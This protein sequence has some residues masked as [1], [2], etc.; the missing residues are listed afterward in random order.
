MRWRPV[1]VSWPMTTGMKPS[2]NWIWVVFSPFSR[3]LRLS[4]MAVSITGCCHFTVSLNSHAV[5]RLS[6]SIFP[7]GEGFP[8]KLWALSDGHPII[9]HLHRFLAFGEHV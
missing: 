3:R 1:D 2:R 6:L 4:G 7:I 5:Q 8:R 9:L